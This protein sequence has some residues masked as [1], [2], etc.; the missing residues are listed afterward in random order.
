MSSRQK[1]KSVRKN[2]PSTRKWLKRD[3][4]KN[5]KYV[6]KK[7]KKSKAKQQKK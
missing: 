1:I 7:M 5:S 2:T 3:K 6:Q 4:I